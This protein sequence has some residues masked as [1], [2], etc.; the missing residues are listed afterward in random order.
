MRILSRSRGDTTVRDTAPATPPA[1][2]AAMTGCETCS[3]KL[4][5]DSEESSEDLATPGSDYYECEVSGDGSETGV[6][7]VSDTYGRH[8]EI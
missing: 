5:I 2:K 7:S 1:Q 4:T 6:H 3:R 8:G